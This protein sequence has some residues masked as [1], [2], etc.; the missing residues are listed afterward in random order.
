VKRHERDFVALFCASWYRDFPIAAG[1]EELGKRALWNIHVGSV[2]KQCAD[3]MGFFTCFESNRTDAVI[4]TASEKPWAKIEWE[5][6]QPHHPNVNELNKL[7]EAAKDDVKLLVYI[8]Y[9]KEIDHAKNIKTIKTAWQKI[10]KPL[11]VFLVTYRWE[12]GRRRFIS[13]QTHYFKARSHKMVREQPALPW[14]V[15]DTVWHRIGSR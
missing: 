15:K 12:G 6:N 8:G 13:L 3:F 4:Q 11:F 9:S 1:H 5:W 10:D 14:E 7:A 2:V